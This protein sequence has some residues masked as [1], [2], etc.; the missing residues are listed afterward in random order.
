MTIPALDD[1]LSHADA[2]PSLPEI[3]RHLMR[4]LNDELADVD[5]LA[6]QINADPAIVARLLAAANS[7]AFGLSSR[8]ES[9]RQAFLVLGVNRVTGIILA[10][11]LIRRFDTQTQDFD[12]RLLWRHTLG[13]AT[14]AR[15][16]AEQTDID[17]EIAFTAGLLH[18]IGQ[19]L[20]FAAAPEAYAQSLALRKNEDISILLAENTVFGYDHAAAGGMLANAWKLPREISEAI[21]AHHNPDDYCSSG[22][23]LS[24][25][26]HVAEVLSHAL[27]LGEQT[28]NRVPDLSERA[29]ASLGLSWQSLTGRFAE[30]EARYDGIRIALGV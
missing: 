25:L 9:A 2:L 30:I 20:M 23:P 19:L 8:I 4:S 21:S 16:L 13:V 10:T 26:I 12:A 5:T 11:A 17:P 29:V 7:S 6:H 27:D 1:L 3:V 18:D 24:D 14:C 22:N 28:N 15:V